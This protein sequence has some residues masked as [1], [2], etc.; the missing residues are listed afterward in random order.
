[1]GSII[2]VWETARCHCGQ[3]NFWLNIRY[4]GASNKIEDVAGRILVRERETERVREG[5]RERVLRL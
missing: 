2:S 3:Y 4:G 1:V 5:E